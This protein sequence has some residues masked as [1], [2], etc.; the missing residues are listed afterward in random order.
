MV[1]LEVFD[2]AGPDVH[3]RC[4]DPGLIFSRANLTFKRN[5]DLI[6]GQNANLS[7]VSAKVRTGIV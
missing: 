2:M 1:L 5:G 4:I 7:V 6:R 3:C